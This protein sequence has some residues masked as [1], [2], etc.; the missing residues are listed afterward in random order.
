MQREKVGNYND[1]RTIQQ[2]GIFEQMHAVLEKKRDLEGFMEFMS[3]LVLSG[4]LQHHDVIIL[5]N[6][7]IHTG[8]ASRRLDD[9]LWDTIV[10]EAPLQIT[11]LWLPARSPEL[12][13]IELVFHI[14]AKRIRQHRYVLGNDVMARSAAVMDL[15]DRQLIVKCCRHCGYDM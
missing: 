12:N 5:D 1:I 6:V 11:V 7:A 15:M 4:W 14:L 3:N 9:F 13:P 2:T 8:G 10:G